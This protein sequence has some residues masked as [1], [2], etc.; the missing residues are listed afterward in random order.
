MAQKQG[1]FGF[2]SRLEWPGLEQRQGDGWAFRPR[3]SKVPRRRP[4]PRCLRETKRII[5]SEGGICVVAETDSLLEGRGFEPSVPRALR[6]CRSANRVSRV[7]T[8]SPGPEPWS[9]SLPSTISAVDEGPISGD[10]GMSKLSM[11]LRRSLD[12]VGPFFGNH[13]D[14]CVGVT[15]D[16]R[17]HDRRVDDAQSLQATHAQLVIDDSYRVVAHLA[18][19]DDVKCGLPGAPGVV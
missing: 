11:R 13:D 9:A 8:A 5:E 7:A 2:G 14:G 12:H 18:C 17:R 19:P 15:R 3:G 16:H 6:G 4:Q 1:G 10:K